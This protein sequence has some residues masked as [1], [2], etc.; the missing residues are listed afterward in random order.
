MK[1]I[2][3]IFK[4]YYSH[5]QTECY[6]INIPWS[7]YG[8]HTMVLCKVSEGLDYAKTLAIGIIN[9]ELIEALN[10]PI[11]ENKNRS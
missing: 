6:K 5:E 8:R 7:N 11:E 10:D 9:K 2:N 1:S 3:P 4:E